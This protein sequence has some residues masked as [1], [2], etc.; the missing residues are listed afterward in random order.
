MILMS[1]TKRI[2]SNLREVS[3]QLPGEVMISKMVEQVS[4]SFIKKA[5][6]RHSE[7]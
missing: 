2:I 6:P 5:L 4:V 1:L 7:G 3:N